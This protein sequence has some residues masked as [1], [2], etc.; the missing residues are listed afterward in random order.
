MDNN[1]NDW[2]ELE[3]TLPLLYVSFLYVH[4]DSPNLVPLQRTCIFFLFYQNNTMAL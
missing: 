4:S 2:S 1:P 3:C